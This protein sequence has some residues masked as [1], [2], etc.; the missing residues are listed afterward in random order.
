MHEMSLKATVRMAILGAIGGCLI[1]VGSLAT[2]YSLL[3]TAGQRVSFANTLSSDVAKLN[4]LTTEL[5]VHQSS[6]VGVQWRHQHEVLVRQLQATPQFHDQT[7]LLIAEIRQR[8]KSIKAIVDGFG[9]GHIA[10]IHSPGGSPDADGILMAAVISQSGAML[11]RTMELQALTTAS[12]TSLKN[13]ALLGLGGTF[14]VLMVGGGLVL[15]LLATI[16]LSHILR[17]RATIQKIS[18]GDLEAEIPEASDN[19]IGDVFR[20]L[21]RMR[22]NLLESMSDLGRAN[23]EL[24]GIKAKLEDRTTSLESANRELEAFASA[25]S[26]DLRAPL[27][28]ISGFSQAILEDHSHQIDEDGRTMLGRVLRATKQ[29]YQLIED[30]LKMSQLSRNTIETSD[31]DLSA[32]V[33]EIAASLEEHEPGRDI[34]ITVAPDVHADCDGRLLRIA[35]NNLL[36]NAWKFTLRTESASIEF[37]EMTSNGRR[38]YFVRDN[39]AGFDMLYSGNLFKPFKRLHSASDFP[40]TGIGLATVARIVGLHGGRIWARSAPGEGATFYFSLS[41]M[42]SKSDNTPLESAEAS[43]AAAAGESAH[44]R[45]VVALRAGQG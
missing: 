32:I 21:D 20:E 19:E 5:F 14:L 34:K 37:G 23:L 26:H 29:M 18:H 43:A 25:V 1:I 4:L 8:L 44:K 35:L 36:G 15:L 31:I 30:L 22:R 3:F 7:D 33:S 42:E 16:M 13:H 10:Q 38:I 40:G 41:H 6:R 27:R 9:P 12:A 2:A 28:T 45:R 17:L 39:G 24:I 11:S